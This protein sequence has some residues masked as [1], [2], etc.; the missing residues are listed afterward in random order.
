MFN[1]RNPNHRIARKITAATALALAAMLA[2]CGGGNGNSDDASPTSNAAVTPPASPDTA[3]SDTPATSTSFFDSVFLDGIG[4][5]YYQFDAN[6]GSGFYPTATGQTRIY[7]TADANTNFSAT[8]TAILG[9]YVANNDEA[10]VTAE[11]LFM[12]TSSGSSG[13]GGARIF[14]QLPQGYQWGPNG[15][16][17]PLY[18]I[19][20]TI[21]DVAGQP[22]NEMAGR[23]EAGGN[24][25]TLT[26]TSDATP[27]PAGAKIYRQTSKVLVPHLIIKTGSKAQAFASLEK[28]QAYYGGTIQTL[29]G[30]RYLLTKSNIT[31]AEYN[32]AVYMANV[33][34]AGDIENAMPSGYNRI[35]ADFIVQEQQKMGL[36]H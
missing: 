36:P 15:V 32:G 16:S 33:R 21:E 31:Y 11:G 10:Y 26:L 34:N 35:A 17:A 4:A 22:I 2:A 9:P 1:V 8:S 29:G 14:Q 13:L 7:V 19:A 12:A 27:M 18:E 23:D 3:A 20:L 30:Y 28:A 6:Y 24:G 25:L 5:G